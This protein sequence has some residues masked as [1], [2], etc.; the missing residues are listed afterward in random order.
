MT[1]YE[2][3]GELTTDKRSVATSE[4]WETQTDWEAY[5]SK[6]SIRIN[7]GVL[8]LDYAI[9]PSVEHYWPVDEGSG[10]TIADNEGSIDGSINGSTWQSLSDAVGGYYLSY[11]NT[12]DYDSL[13]SDPFGGAFYSGAFTI[14]AFVRDDNTS[15]NNAVFAHESGPDGGVEFRID[16]GNIH[17]V[18][19]GVSNIGSSLSLTSSAWHF[20]AV[21][22]EPANDQAIFTLD[23]TNETV[24][25]TDTPT[26]PPSSDAR[27]GLRSSGSNAFGGG[28]DERTISF[29]S[30]SDSDIQ[31]LYERRSDV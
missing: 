5:Q 19:H 8:E 27:F 31:D 1:E 22:F 12:D 25:T 6:D 26:Q 11:D 18:F 28:I 20:V 23:T 7:S 14:T 9:P 2:S 10:S 4:T 24:S 15:E 21:R 30:L 29:S 3:S 17:L 16:S 13:G